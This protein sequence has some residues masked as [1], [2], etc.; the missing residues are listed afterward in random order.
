VRLEDCPTPALVLDYEKLQANCEQMLRRAADLGV[1]LRPH[2]KTLKSVEAAR[3]AIDP[4]HGGIA[5]STLKE[6]EFFA[7]AGFRDIQ[8][9]VCAPPDKLP[10]IARVLRTA[11]EFSFFVDNISTARALTDYAN[12]HDEGFRIWIE[13]DSGEHRTGLAPDDPVLLEVASLLASEPRVT[14]CGVATHAGHSYG[15]RSADAIRAIAEQERLE[16]TRAAATLARCGIEVP[17]VSAG[18]TPTAMFGAS[19]A[20]LTEL[21]AGVYMAGDMFQAALGCLPEQQISVSVLATVISHQPSHNQIVIDAGALALSK[22]RSTAVLPGGDVGYGMV[23]D[24]AG[25]PTFGRLFVTNVHQEHGEIPCPDDSSFERLP[26]GAR[27]RVL[28]NHACI[29]AAQYE[30]FL[31]VKGQEVVARWTRVNG[32]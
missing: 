29:T 4:T 2:V 24:V 20:G 11:P 30:E 3:L 7:D 6:A 10:R 14:L 9:A 13:V 28:P 26:I 1:K 32:W 15:A 19:G 5:V 17:G 27:V 18:S 21:R 8:L 31:V 16:V 23:T 12:C 22:D 25:E